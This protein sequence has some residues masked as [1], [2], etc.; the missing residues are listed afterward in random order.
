[1]DGAD[2]CAVLFF[3]IRAAIDEGDRVIR[4]A[5]GSAV[6]VGIVNLLLIPLLGAGITH[7]APRAGHPMLIAFGIILLTCTAW[8]FRPPL[9]A[10]L[11]IGLGGVI[12]AIVLVPRNGHFVWPRQ[13]FEIALELLL[14][15]PL[16]ASILAA[17]V[18]AK[19]RARPRRAEPPLE[20]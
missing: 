6:L 10:A 13:P 11:Q 1:M 18:G 16:A 14:L 20:R 5:S 9:G 3:A 17:V 2:S 12:A 7:L 19:R 15:V 8:L 4:I